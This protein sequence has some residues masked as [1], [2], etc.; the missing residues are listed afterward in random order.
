MLLPEQTVSKE[1]EIPELVDL[2]DVDEAQAG[3]VLCTTG[4][5]NMWTCNSGGMPGA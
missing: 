3:R 2:L 1:Y 4:S 5:V